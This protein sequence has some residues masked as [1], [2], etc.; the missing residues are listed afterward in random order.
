MTETKGASTI[1]LENSAFN[2]IFSPLDTY[3]P[4]RSVNRESDIGFSVVGILTVRYTSLFE[5]S[6]SEG[7][8]LIISPPFKLP[9]IEI[10]NSIVDCPL[11]VDVFMDS[12]VVDTK[13]AVSS[14]SIIVIIKSDVFSLSSSSDS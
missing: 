5:V 9:L 6:S 7:V 11:I 10:P 3:D 4:S 1:P 2:S 8:I 13:E 14:S 12:G